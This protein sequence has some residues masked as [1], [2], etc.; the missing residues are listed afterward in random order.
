MEETKTFRVVLASPS[1]V[2]MERDQ[3]PSVI[4]DI[5][6]NLRAARFALKLRMEL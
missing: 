3:L 1:D 4:E 6:Q 5:N 2:Q